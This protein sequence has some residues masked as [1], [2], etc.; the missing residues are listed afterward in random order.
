MPTVAA[1]V[2]TAIAGL[3]VLMLG[4]I[5]YLISSGF[6]GLKEQ[7]RVL[8]DKIDKHQTQAE[9]NAIAIAEINARCS[10]LHANHKRAE[11]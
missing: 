11:D 2:W 1:I 8:W 6:T 4:I 3:I 9:A 10:L 5:G 7:L